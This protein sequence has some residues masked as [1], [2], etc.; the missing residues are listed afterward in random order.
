MAYTF[1][2]ENKGSETINY[3]YEILVDDVIKNVDKAI[4]V[5]VYRN[6]ERTV[7][8]K[9]NEKTGWNRQSKN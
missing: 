8:A 5:M 3:W 2:V 9:A 1:Y 4:R 7:Y 6:G